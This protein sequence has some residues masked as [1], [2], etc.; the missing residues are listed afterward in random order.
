MALWRP[1]LGLTEE[2]RYPLYS[3][4]NS[5]LLSST[6]FR[7]IVQAR[8]SESL[9]YISHTKIEYYDKQIR[10]F[11][12]KIVCIY[13]CFPSYWLLAIIGW[14]VRC[15]RTSKRPANAAAYLLYR[16]PIDH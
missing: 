9:C 12:R 3:T 13:P 15:C 5:R 16:N 14:A 2:P 4:M 8:E 10:S 7:N 6:R 11:P 1:G